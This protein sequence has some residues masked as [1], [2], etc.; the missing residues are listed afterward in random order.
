[1]LVHL[2]DPRNTSKTCAQCGHCE[3]TNRRSQAEFVC[4]SCGHVAA[5]DV[6]AAVNIA[7]RGDVM[8]PIVSL[9]ETG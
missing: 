9:A 2:V 8:R 4:K 6:N 3:R 1:V 5:A 7:A